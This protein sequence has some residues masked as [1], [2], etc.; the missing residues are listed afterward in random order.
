MSRRG[1]FVRP[2]A[3]FYWINNNTD[4]SSNHAGRVGATIG[5]T[6]R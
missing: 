5:Y 4:F 1:F 6:F 2:E 3:R